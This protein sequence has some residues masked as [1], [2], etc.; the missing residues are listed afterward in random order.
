MKLFR[1]PT[2]TFAARTSS[3]T[4]GRV[5]EFD[6]D[7]FKVDLPFLDILSKDKSLDTLATF[8]ADKLGQPLATTG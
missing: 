3:S 6:L 8:V 5:P 4:P 7:S 1:R 2:T